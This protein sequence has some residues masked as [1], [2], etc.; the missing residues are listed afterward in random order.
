[1]KIGVE[2]NMLQEGLIRNRHWSEP[3]DMDYLVIYFQIG[4]GVLDYKLLE[5]SSHTNLENRVC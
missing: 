4:H 1:M 2:Y 3:R 5:D